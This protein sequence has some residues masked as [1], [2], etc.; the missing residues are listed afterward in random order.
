MNPDITAIKKKGEKVQIRPCTI[1]N[2]SILPF[3]TLLVHLYPSR[4]AY[5]LVFSL[6]TNIAPT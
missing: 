2:F 4:L 3:V 1:R 5:R 6:T